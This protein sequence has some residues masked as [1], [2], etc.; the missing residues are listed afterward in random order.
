MRPTVVQ[1]RPL[2][3]R[4]RPNET[5]QVFQELP[6]NPMV[7]CNPQSHCILKHDRQQLGGGLRAI[8][9]LVES[10]I[11]KIG[12]ASNVVDVHMR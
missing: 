6:D 4:D 8:N 2:A 10:G 12:N 5:S 1:I 3:I 11:K 7:A 9:W